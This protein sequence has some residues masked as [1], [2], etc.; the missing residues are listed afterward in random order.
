MKAE[1]LGFGERQMLR[2]SRVCRQAPRWVLTISVIFFVLS[3]AG[4][5]K[6][7]VFQTSRNDLISDK[8]AFHAVQERFLKE[9][10][11]ADDVVIM[12]EGQDRAEREA[13]VDLL[14]RLLSQDP[15]NF[16]A[17]FPKVELPFL[18]SRALLF[19][20]ESDLKALVE[21]VAQARPFLLALSSPEGLARLLADFDSTV[22]GSNEDKLVSMLPFLGDIFHELRRAVETRGRVPYRSPW[23]GLLFGDTSPELAE[24][25]QG[26]LLDTSF[27]HTTANGTIHLL[28]F[29]FVQCQADSIAALHDAVA[30]AHRAYPKLVVGITGEPLL[31]YDEMLSSQNDST[32]SGYLSMI[33]VALLFGLTFHQFGRPLAIQGSFVLG[34]GWSL[35]VATLVIG[36]LNLLTVSFFTI[37]VGCGIDYGI[38]LV[39]RY[40]DVYAMTG[41]K[42]KALDDSLIRT[43]TDI[44]VGAIAN[45]AAFFAIGLTDFKGV[46]E[47]GIIAGWGV[48]L[49]FVATVLPL[50]AILVL[51]DHQRKATQ[52]MT[53]GLGL[54]A[55]L[56]RGQD[57]L[58]RKA[59][60]VVFA[61]AL[62]VAVEAPRMASVG[63]DYNLLHM[64]DP[65]LDSVQ[66]ELKLVE[67]G[68]NTMLFGVALA[69]DLAHARKLKERF[70]ALPEVS[71]VETI[72][73]L[74]PE[75]TEA[76]LDSLRQLR[77]LVKD[78]RIPKPDDMKLSSGSRKDLEQMG[79]GF[80][81]LEKLFRAERSRLL[82]DPSKQVRDDTK[83]F[84]KEMDALFTE[85]SA[86]GPGPIEDGLTHFQNHFFGDLEGMV[87]FLQQQ[88][89]DSRLTLQDLP[90]NLRLRSVGATGKLVLRIYPKHNIWEREALDRFVHAIRNVDPSAVGAPVMIWHHTDVM[91]RAFETAGR[92]AVIAVLLILALY[93]RSLAWA[94]AALVPLT[95]GVLFMLWAMAIHG[96]SFNLANFMGLPLLLGVGV[97][98]AIHVVH[99]SREEKNFNM[100]CFSTGPAV[101]LSAGTTVA[102]FGTLALGGHQ[103]IAS[104]GFI[105]SVGI[106]GI[107]LAALVV[108]PAALQVW[109][110]FKGGDS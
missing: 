82:K 109:N 29:R 106:V 107:V 71:H 62:L 33:L 21:A 54:R 50:P 110:P 70:E 68:G 49:C 46:S 57:F 95:L 26:G 43:G 66:T 53:P 103:G 72:S 81:Q 8:D 75:V 56:A 42:E 80:M 90:E 93:F 12:V 35:G 37:L 45:A 41:D 3:L 84:E 92:N 99:R 76:K 63:F 15:S 32:R 27:Y 79:E 30:K 105:L 108:L 20:P 39:L 36:H 14:A 69:D 13:F 89:P 91:K 51:L 48:L 59:F 24:R 77:N 38:H 55:W 67:K 17:V 97:G 94:L 58:L 40:E 2:C 5:A 73:D 16:H 22:A 61:T 65:H 87:S 11:G 7:L 96:V 44:G 100:F 83:K 60:W 4:A 47:L 1:R 104:L 25:T 28:V 78:I 23:G 18:S 52:K 102:G 88:D 74:F 19:L 101:L 98:F 85:L 34:A 86:L 64:Q 31:E 9:F 6:F 10:P